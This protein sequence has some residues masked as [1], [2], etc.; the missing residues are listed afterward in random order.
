MNYGSTF[1]FHWYLHVF[2]DFCSLPVVFWTD[3][4][5][6]NSHF[7][8]ITYYSWFPETAK[9][10]NKQLYNSRCQRK[11]PQRSIF[12]RQKFHW[13]RGAVFSVRY[14]PRYTQDELRVS[15]S[16]K[17]VSQSENCCGSVFMSCCY[18][19][20]VTLARDSFGTKRKG[21]VRR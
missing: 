12:P 6:F 21:N 13:T 2:I 3:K 15:P 18:K 14:V 4:L 16:V 8:S 9:P 5:V 10:R 19:K 20:L 7:S 17:T 11:A 1:V